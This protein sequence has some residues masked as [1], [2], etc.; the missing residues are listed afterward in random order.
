M[1]RDDV[2]GDEPLMKGYLGILKNGAYL[3]AESLTAIP[4]L[5]S[6]FVLEVIDLIHASTVGAEGFVLPAN[7]G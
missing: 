4:T 5:M 2:D 7:R 1:A 3:D 6:L